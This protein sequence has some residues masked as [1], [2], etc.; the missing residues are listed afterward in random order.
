MNLNPYSYPLRFAGAHH[1]TFRRR[2]KPMKKHVILSLRQY[3]EDFLDDV[4]LKE[5]RLS[6]LS[7]TIATLTRPDSDRRS[8]HRRQKPLSSRT[9][10]GLEIHDRRAKEEGAQTMGQ[11]HRRGFQLS[12]S[13]RTPSISTST[14]TVVSSL[15]MTGCAFTQRTGTVTLSPS[16][17]KTGMILRPVPGRVRELGAVPARRFSAGTNG[18]AWTRA[19]STR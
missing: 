1:K 7:G 18:P 16:P 8:S 15:I 14:C 3:P 11:V 4:T 17:D 13:S 12:I 5:R 10:E 6:E 19:C 2:D 9:A